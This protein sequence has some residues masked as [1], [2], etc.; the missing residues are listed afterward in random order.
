MVSLAA[1]ENMFLMLY[2]AGC[3]LGCMSVCVCVF[4]CIKCARFCVHAKL[5]VIC[6]LGVLHVHVC[7]P[8]PDGGHSTHSGGL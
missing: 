4:T 6:L 2:I 3:M 8:Y 5:H 1:A 7:M